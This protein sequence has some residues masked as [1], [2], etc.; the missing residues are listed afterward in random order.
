MGAGIL[1]AV[2]TFTTTSTARL[3]V[4]V[5]WTFATNNIDV[6][7]ARGGPCTVDQVNQKTCLFATFSESTSAKPERLTISLEAGTYQRFPDPHCS[8]AGAV[9]DA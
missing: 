4:T 3:E 6:Y 5:D 7:V 9:S 1:Y 2:G 8:R